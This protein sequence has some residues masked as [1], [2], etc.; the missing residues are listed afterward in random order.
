MVRWT[1]LIG[2]LLAVGS[3]LFVYD[4][5]YDIKSKYADKYGYLEGYFFVSIPYFLAF[6]VSIAAVVLR[7]RLL[8]HFVSVL[9][10]LILACLPIVSVL[11]MKRFD[12]AG[13]GSSSIGYGASLAIGVSSLAA[14]LISLFSLAYGIVVLVKGYPRFKQSEEPSHCVLKTRQS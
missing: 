13:L 4:L 3:S 7:R 10:L 11:D 9:L 2:S 6:G 14:Y 5:Y 12:E 8:L 1:S